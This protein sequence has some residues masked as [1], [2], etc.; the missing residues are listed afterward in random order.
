LA[1]EKLEKKYKMGN[2]R[3][4]LKNMSNIKGSQVIN[5]NDAPIL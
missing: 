3:K 2:Q 5:K 1:G 4:I